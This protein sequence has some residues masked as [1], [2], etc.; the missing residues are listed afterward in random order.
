MQSLS[1]TLYGRIF[2]YQ[3]SAARLLATQ[4]EDNREEMRIRTLREAS[5][6]AISIAS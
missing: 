1:V 2:C 4:A 5:C 6:V 3:Q